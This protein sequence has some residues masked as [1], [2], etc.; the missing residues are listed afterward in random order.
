MSSMA[1]LQSR[2]PSSLPVT[3]S[4]VMEAHGIRHKTTLIKE[5]G[6]YRLKRIPKGYGL[7]GDENIMQTE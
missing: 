6:K 4:K 3:D 5:D 1:S 2:C 7:S